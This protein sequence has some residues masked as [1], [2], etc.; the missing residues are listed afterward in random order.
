M[1]TPN[2]K[3]DPTDIDTFYTRAEAVEGRALGASELRKVICNENAILELPG[4]IRLCQHDDRPRAIII[5]DA[6]P[7]RR[8]D[9][10]L[11]PLVRRIL[12]EAGIAVETHTF[13]TAG[14]QLKTTPETIAEARS[15]IDPGAAI[16]ALGSGCITDIVKHACFEVEEQ[17]GVQ[18]VLIA[19]Q[20]ANS[21]CAFTSRMTV[22]TKNGV[23]RTV[24]SRLA[25]TLI[26]DT[27]ILRDAPALYRTGG[28]GDVAVGASTFADLQ[29]ADD[30]NMGA[31]NQ[32]AY[33]SSVDLREILLSGHPVIRDTG[34]AGQEAAGKLLTIAG[35]ALTVSGDSAP[36]S[37][38]EHVTSHM[39][40]MVAKANA[41]PVSN[42]GHQCALATVLTLLL[43]DE[44]RA[45]LEPST[46]S[47]QACFPE[48]ADMEERIGN[49]FRHIDATG[50][51]ARECLSDYTQKLANWKKNRPVF[52]NYLANWKAHRVALETHLMPV[53]AFVNILRSFGHPMRFEDLEVPLTRE[54]VRWAFFNAHLM[55][56]R[57]TIGDFAYFCGMFDEETCTR[58]FQKFDALTST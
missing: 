13:E 3:F 45:R 36:L 23:K 8:G 21:V 44:V 5:Q 32:T 35:L 20:T 15:K 40:D 27:Q 39:L 56:K 16:V 46:L 22:I 7:M 47:L 57:F 31:W 54:E 58:I 25:N 18:P 29:L 14:D 34:L 28:L 53:D 30:L 41:R 12:E 26:L 1:Q 52:E 11:K 24:P 4:I 43:Y 49:T 9:C 19:V 2:F 10:A 17:R 50:D 38:Y 33:E 6:T 37:G 51:A 55:R 48:Q 42:H